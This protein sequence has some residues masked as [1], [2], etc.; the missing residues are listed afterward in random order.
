M[1]QDKWISERLRPIETVTPPA[2]AVPAGACDCHMHVFGAAECYPGV[3]EARYTLP[4]GS[5]EQYRA[6]ADL[7]KLE[8]A[9][10]VQP[11]Y[12]GTDNSC[13]LDAMAQFG[14]P[15]RGVVFIPDRPQASL[16]KSLDRC[17]VRGIR[18]DFFKASLAGAS[19]M[20]ILAEL[21]S[22]AHIAKDMGWH[23]ELYS[24]GS[25][26]RDLLD[27][28]A[29]LDV[30]FSV[31]HLGYMKQEHGLTDADFDRFV[32][33]AKTAHCWVKLTGP[34][35]VAPD[36]Q[37]DLTDRMA[38]MLIAAAPRR[39]VWGTDW[40]HL[41][42]GSRDTG[43]LFNRLARWCPDEDAR[44]DILVRNPARLYRFE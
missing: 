20:N 10:F 42:H 11:S 39:V 16:I 6:L 13:L 17:G 32:E 22:A 8:R 24:P 1:A 25:V 31:N 9:V 19:R 33:L 41:P 26:T 44:H 4:E 28:L 14:R 18:L 38:R 37:A 34:Y 35:R 5:L 2:F 23:V 7:L 12:Y 27:E 43:E 36:E 21:K 3:P 29:V 15:C 30:D 40:P